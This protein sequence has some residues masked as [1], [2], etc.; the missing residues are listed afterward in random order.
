MGFHQE[1]TNNSL[2]RSVPKYLWGLDGKFMG[3]K[4]FS[5]LKEGA[6]D[7]SGIQQKGGVKRKFKVASTFL[8][9]P[10]EVSMHSFI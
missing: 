10:T 4:M 5:T 3:I 2:N 1:R 8:K 6:K 7:L 9:I